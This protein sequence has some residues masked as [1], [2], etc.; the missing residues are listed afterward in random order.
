MPA[1]TVAPARS[2]RKV[3][4]TKE[5]SLS[6]DEKP[7]IGFLKSSLGLDGYFGLCFF[8]RCFDTPAQVVVLVVVGYLGMHDSTLFLRNVVHTF[9]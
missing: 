8:C 2:N 4:W 7:L 3:S 1:H 5:D 6:H 9:L